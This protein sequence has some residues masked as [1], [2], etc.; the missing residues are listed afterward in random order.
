M[1]VDF[2]HDRFPSN[3][4]DQARLQ[5]SPEAGC[6]P[7]KCLHCGQRFKQQEDAIVHSNRCKRSPAN[8]V[9][10]SVKYECFIKPGYHCQYIEADNSESARRQFAELIRDNLEAEHI[11]ANNLDTNDGEDPSP[12]AEGE[13][14]AASART[15]H[16]L[17]GS[18]DGDK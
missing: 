7:W 13:S 11:I 15:L 6:S 5:P 2:I 1:L 18:L 3:A 16:P 8:A 17:V 12:N 9:R 4:P 10:R 14:R